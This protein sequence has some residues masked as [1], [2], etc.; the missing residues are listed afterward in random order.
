MS[1]I[2]PWPPPPKGFPMSSHAEFSSYQLITCMEVDDNEDV[3]P[4]CQE[5]P[6]DPVQTRCDHIYCQECLQTWTAGHNTCPSCR[7]E[8]Y[9]KYDIPERRLVTIM[10]FFYGLL[11]YDVYDHEEVQ[12]ELEYFDKLVKEGE[13]PLVIDDDLVLNGNYHKI[14]PTVV[15]VGIWFW[16]KVEQ[17]YEPH[18]REMFKKDW[19]KVIHLL[20]CVL[21]FHDDWRAR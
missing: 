13:P 8:L 17:D 10:P 3:C 20:D 2:H 5:E 21:L 7:K 9:S 14:Q 12:Y 1:P 16:N 4:I 6:K 19:I 11:T 18:L 15:A